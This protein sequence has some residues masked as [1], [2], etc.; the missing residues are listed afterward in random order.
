L[1]RCTSPN[2]RTGHLLA[3]PAPG[4]LAYKNPLRALH[5]AHTIPRNLPDNL[6]LL[7]SLS[8]AV[9]VDAGELLG[10]GGATAFGHRW[11]NGRREVD[12]KSRRNLFC[13]AASNSP[14]PA[15]LAVAVLFF[16]DRR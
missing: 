14:S 13:P 9:D 15:S 12:E 10:A 4:L 1:T 6:S 3:T 2:N 7:S 16:T 5:Q 8:V 11:K